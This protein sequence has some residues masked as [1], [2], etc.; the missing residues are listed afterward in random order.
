MKN[1]PNPV[2][3][4]GTYEIGLSS[5]EYENIVAS[6]LFKESPLQG[7]YLA[8]AL[9]RHEI[10]IPSIEVSPHLVTVA[11]FERF[12]TATGY[13]TEAE[14]DGWG[15]IWQGGWKKAGDVSWQRPCGSE[16]D[17]L[18]LE[19]ALHMPVLQVSWN[20]AA[21]YCL[22]QSDRQGRFIRLLSEGEWEVAA[23]ILGG[24]EVSGSLFSLEENRQEEYMALLHRESVSLTKPVI[25]GLAWEWT[26]DWFKPYGGG[27]A[28]KEFGEVYRVMRGGSLLSHELQCRNWYRFRRCPTA[29]SPFYSFRVCMENNG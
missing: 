24:S 11:Q 17:R 27:P 9:P 21:A 19:G 18:Y 20:D 7:E 1:P 8:N 2:I 14:V 25:G 15:W 4:P 22:W 29:R 16:A 23:S 13:R 12:V 10:E 5:E 6:S 26:A 28:N 3:F